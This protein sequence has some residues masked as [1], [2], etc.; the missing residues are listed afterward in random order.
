MTYLSPGTSS[1]SPKRHVRFTAR[2]YL[3]GIV[4]DMERSIAMRT[5]ILMAGLL[6]ASVTLTGWANEG[7][8]TQ[9]LDQVTAEIRDQ[10]GL[11]ASEAIDPANVP[12]ELLIELGDAVMATIHPD[13]RTHEWMDRMMGGEGSSSLDAA[14]RWMAYRYLTGGYGTPGNAGGMG[15]GMMGPGMMNGS[16][17]LMGNPNQDYSSVPSL[18]PEQILQRRLS[19]GEITRRQYRRML[20][21]LD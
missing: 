12:D 7:D 4:Q 19:S 2:S 21:A 1:V 13:E 16:W 18:S 17:G 9:S 5:R 14:H 6:L 10:L 15:F 20:R 8:H 11:D 3:F